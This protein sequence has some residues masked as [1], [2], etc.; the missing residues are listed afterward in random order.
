MH[1]VSGMELQVKVG[2]QAFGILT[3]FTDFPFLSTGVAMEK[4]CP[5]TFSIL[6]PMKG[7]RAAIPAA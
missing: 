1:L 6:G 3:D 5:W 7:Y 4:N 2:S